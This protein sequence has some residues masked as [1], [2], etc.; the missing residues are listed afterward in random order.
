L[1][2]LSVSLAQARAMAQSVDLR[3]ALQSVWPKLVGKKLGVFGA[4]S[5]GEKIEE[6]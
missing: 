5:A 4:Q 2:V 3:L 1:V 6:G